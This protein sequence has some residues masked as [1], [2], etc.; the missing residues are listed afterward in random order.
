MKD[1]KMSEVE[2]TTLPKFIMRN[3]LMFERN[4]NMDRKP[5]SGRPRIARTQENV[6]KIRC[7]SIDIV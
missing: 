6:V 4:A 7:F 2:K 3:M 5:G 1:M